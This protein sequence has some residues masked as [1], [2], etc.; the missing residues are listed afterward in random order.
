[1]NK[2]ELIYL[3]VSNSDRVFLN[4]NDIIAV[5]ADR[6]T[7]DNNNDDDN[8]NNNISIESQGTKLEFYMNDKS[9]FE[10]TFSDN[11]PDGMRVIRQL[12]NFVSEEAFR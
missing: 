8:N 7:M 3:K 10:Y 4:A 2:G 12:K 11:D 1:M 9:H 5:L 6:I